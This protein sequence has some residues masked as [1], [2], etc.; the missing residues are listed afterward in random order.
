[1]ASTYPTALDTFAT[2]AL[3]STSAATRHATAHNDNADAINKIEREMGT[4]PGW[5]PTMRSQP[6]GRALMMTSAVIENISRY[7]A[8]HT[9]QGMLVSGTIR[10]FPIGVLRANLAVASLTL[11]A[12]TAGAGATAIW[13]GIARLSDLQVLA[14]SNNSTTLPTANAMYTMTFSATYTP[15]ADTPVL[16]FINFTGTTVPQ[17]FGVSAG[18]AAMQGTPAINGSSTTGQTA[19]PIAVGATLAAITTAPQVLYAQL[20]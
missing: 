13:G 5:G 17:F 1:M 9:T 14:R 8:A 19:T 16:G 7:A 6:A 20:R 3:D 4:L 10:V 12:S 15:T 18:M 2:D 11:A